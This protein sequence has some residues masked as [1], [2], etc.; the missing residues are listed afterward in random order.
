[1][2][3]E[4][5][6]DEEAAQDRFVGDACD[7]TKCKERGTEGAGGQAVRARKEATDGLEEEDERLTRAS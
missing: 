5:G 7:E 1:M 2:R 3:F 6:G 4:Q